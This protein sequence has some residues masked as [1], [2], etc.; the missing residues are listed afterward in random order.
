MIG[1]AQSP[2][3]L[4]WARALAGMPDL[5]LWVASSRGFA[6]GFDGVVPAGRRLALN[7]SPAAGGGNIAVLARLPALGAWLRRVDADWLHAHYLT[8]HGTLAWLA[9]R[10]WRLRGQLI[11]SAW[12]SD[13]LLT[14]QRSRAY[15]VVTSRVLRACRL[16]TSDSEHM[17]A[18]LRE[19]GA[20]EVM[21]FPFG[22]DVL[23]AESEA[24]QP[25]L[26]F[27]N[28]ALEPLYRPEQVLALFAQQLA[29]Q[30][31][32]RL[33]VANDGSLA[34]TLPA[35]ARAL[36]LSVGRIDAGQQVEFTGRLDAAAQAAWYARAQWWVS[37]PASDSV[38]VSLLEAMAHGCIPLLSDL[39]AN[40]EWVRDG[41][42]GSIVP[43]ASPPPE[44]ALER[45]LDRAAAIAQAN[46]AQVERDGLFAPAV[47]HFVARLRELTPR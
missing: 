3:L 14:P 41:D 6:A 34:G 10:L 38:A 25:W 36:G 8:S 46:R 5:E 28:R 20:R 22:L 24:K 26:F 33:V 15:R 12:G 11:G 13:I 45:L 4:K 16:C 7:T 44:L 19:L 30:P 1:D 23:P 21:T 35:Q 40:R 43:D 39:P 9:R 2:H 29:R 18:R 37:L 31:Q 47:A 32:G 27:A 42:N 17:A